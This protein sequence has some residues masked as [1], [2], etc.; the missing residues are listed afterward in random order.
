MISNLLGSPPIN[1]KEKLVSP[2]LVD[3][4]ERRQDSI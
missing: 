1:L 3:E 4:Q 2:F